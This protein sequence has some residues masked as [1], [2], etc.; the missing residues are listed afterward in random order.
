MIHGGRNDDKPL[1]ILLRWQIKSTGSANARVTKGRETLDSTFSS[2]TTTTST[3]ILDCRLVQL[4]KKVLHLNRPSQVPQLLP[5]AQINRRPV[6]M[7][8]R[9]SLVIRI[10]SRSNTLADMAHQSQTL[11]CPLQQ[12]P[13]LRLLTLRPSKLMHP[14]KVLWRQNRTLRK[15]TNL[16][17]LQVLE[18]AQ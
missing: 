3:T 17:S 12:F 14:L 2:T 13:S 7:R 5:Q 16:D 18:S 8:S 6:K 9:A 10:S 4:L 15:P 1:V 11:P